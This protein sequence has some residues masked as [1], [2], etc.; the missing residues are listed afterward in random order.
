V[1]AKTKEKKFK[2]FRFT[3]TENAGTEKENV[4]SFDVAEDL[5]DLLEVEEA[6]AKV[7]APGTRVEAQAL[8]LDTGKVEKIKIEY[9]ADQT[10]DVGG[11]GVAAKCLQAKGGLGGGQWWFDESG[12]LVKYV[13]PSSLG[14]ITTTRVADSAAAMP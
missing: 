8:N 2:G 11:A 6:L 12:I 10:L 7:T 1:A 14:K 13:G 9:V 4:K 5:Y 3:L